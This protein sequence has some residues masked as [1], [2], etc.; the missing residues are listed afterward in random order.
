MEKCVRLRAT[1]RDRPRPTPFARQ[2]WSW[3]FLDPANVQRL[4]LSPAA[5]AAVSRLLAAV[6]VPQA[7]QDRLTVP[8]VAR[9]RTG[10]RT[11][12]FRVVWTEADEQ[13]LRLLRMHRLRRLRSRSAPVQSLNLAVVAVTTLLFASLV[14]GRLSREEAPRPPSGM[15]RFSYVPIAAASVPSPDRDRAAAT[16]T[17]VR[18]EHD[19]GGEVVALRSSDPR[20]LLV[21]YCRVGLS[22][23]CDPVELAYADSPDPEM[24]YGI[25][26]SFLDL[27][28]IRIRRDRASRE[29]VAGNGLEPIAELEMDR[30]HLSA[31]RIPLP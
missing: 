18:I 3:T 5:R 10:N 11:N 1:L 26:R 12:L 2:T 22:A 4:D 14:G 27:R 7:L 8:V 24:R 30:L 9:T 25:F 28:A 20:S 21:G 15:A 29:W 23:F 13:K 6:H 19:P 17:D 16:I 31:T